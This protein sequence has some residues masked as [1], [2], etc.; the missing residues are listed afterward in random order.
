MIKKLYDR[1]ILWAGYKYANLFLAILTSVL[2]IMYKGVPVSSY[3]I[4]K[5]IKNEKL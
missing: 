5:E 1:C 2:V 3:T 4:E